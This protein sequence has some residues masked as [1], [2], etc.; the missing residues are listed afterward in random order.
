MF[1]V[2]FVS[3]NVLAESSV[4]ASPASYDEAVTRVATLCSQGKP[5]AFA[6]YVSNTSFNEATGVVNYNLRVLW[7]SCSA[8]THTRAFAV[9][10]YPDTSGSAVCPMVGWYGGRDTY[11]CVKYVGNPKWS[12]S[13]GL[14][15]FGGASRNEA[16]VARPDFTSIEQVANEPPVAMQ[17]LT[18]PRDGVVPGWN[19]KRQNNGEYTF[20]AGGQICAY[21]KQ[22]RA[23]G[24]WDGG[25]GGAM[26]QSLSVT[27]KWSKSHDVYPGISASQQAIAPG[28]TAQMD[29]F[30]QNSGGQTQGYVPYT[31]YEFVSPSGVQPDYTKFTL[32]KSIGATTL[33]Y[34]EGAPY[35]INGQQGCPW[36]KANIYNNQPG[37]DCRPATAFNAST[38]FPTG[39]SQLSNAVFN[40]DDYKVGDRVCRFTA[41]RR[42]DA[43]HTGDDATRR[44][45]APACVVI[46]KRPTVQV[47][48]GD[49]AARG[50]ID[51]SLTRKASGVFGSWVEY[52]AISA[53]SNKYFAS[54]AGLVGQSSPTQAN[55]SK[56][57]FANTPSACS[58]GS[59][60]CYASKDSFR[61]LPQIAQYFTS[62]PKEAYNTG[63][64]A[65]NAFATGSAVKVRDAG[66]SVS[67]GNITLEP[68]Q[69]AVIL[70]DSVT[71]TGDIA[72]RDVA[73]TRA[74]E[75]PQLVI[76]AK[77]INIED[78]VSNIDAWLIA[79]GAINTCSNVATTLTT[80]LCS[81]PLTV[82]G[83][84]V[85]G[86]L[87]LRRTAGAGD[88]A[89]S[90]V[91]AEVI[92]L[93]P[94]AYLWARLVADGPGRIETV[95]TIELP[96]RF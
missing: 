14:T 63:S 46:G 3:P 16:C 71:I 28:E 44:I 37:I 23:N 80:A 12:N 1:A 13:S 5:V 77:N 19:Q 6:V 70:A 96:P 27:V 90:G 41:I 7:R 32:T 55:W 2:L 93:R 18:L 9:T 87:L 58:E 24:S 65:S 39:Y 56:L 86:N 25:I 59:Y 53:G 21:Y 50:E 38:D 54:A 94:D 36:F 79:S 40:G 66:A 51:T 85:A 49:V 73:Y 78:S 10:G 95:S 62:L 91:P 17:R 48:G 45:G 61:Q 76:I 11:D 64:F 72:Y 84:V 33:R 47:W 69:S 29:A 74:R 35:P 81:R 43:A 22:Q 8:A 15:C 34:L 4:T 26:C 60:G 89:A 83:P 31:V 75:L 57:T 30:V 82:H 88:G 68:G 92:N 52:A 20:G 42:F 67:L